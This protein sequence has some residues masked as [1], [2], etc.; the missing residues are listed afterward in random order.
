VIDQDGQ[1]LLTLHQGQ[2][3]SNHGVLH[4]YKRRVL[5]GDGGGGE[6]EARGGGV[7]HRGHRGSQ[8]EGCDGRSRH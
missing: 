6:E 4:G 7:G 3:N 8:A 5:Q 1:N 2:Q